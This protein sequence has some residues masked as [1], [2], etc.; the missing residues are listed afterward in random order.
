MMKNA[1]ERNQALLVGDMEQKQDEAES[2]ADEIF[3]DLQQEINELQRRRSELQHLEGTK[4]P[5]HLIQVS[6]I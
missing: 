1:F 2:R 5:L 3:K 4:D 6:L